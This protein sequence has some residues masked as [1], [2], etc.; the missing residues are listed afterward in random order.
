MS[1]LD[2]WNKVRTPD[3]KYTKSFSRGGGFKGT[4]TNT[5][6]A[7][8]VATELWGQNGKGWGL[9]IVDE[10]YVPGAPI[11]VNDNV[12]GNE[13][14]HVVRVQLWY[15]EGEEIYHTSPQYGQTTFVGK[16][17]NGMFT[18]EEAPKKSV[19]DGMLK[20]MSLLGFSA[21]IFMGLYD[22]NKYVN[23]AKA[24][25]EPEQK[26]QGKPVLLPNT[27][28]FIRA[29]ALYRTE[30]SLEKVRHHMTVSEDVAVM[31]F[32]AAADPEFQVA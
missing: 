22:D 25:F 20:C 9:D 24:K 8:M 31:V 7:V 4:A 11:L 16:N 6:Y 26:P 19:T 21:D 29:V 13:I 27:P 14:I 1:N 23:D 15:R 10:Q 3:P 18:D 30:Q 2:L 17:K 28:A 32:D 5:Q 12:V